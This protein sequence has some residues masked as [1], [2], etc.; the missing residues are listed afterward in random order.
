MK[1]FSKAKLI[2]GALF[3]LVFLIWTILVLFIDVKAIG[4]NETR[5]G[6][7]TFNSWFFTLTGVNMTLYYAT[8]ILSL[9]PFFVIFGFALL[10]L[11][12][13][14]K[15][16]SLFRVDFDILMLG[17]HYISVLFSY[18]LFEIIVVNYRPILIESQMEA[19]YPSSTT[20]LI[21]TVMVPLAMQINYRIKNRYIKLLILI[22]ISIFTAFMIIGRILSGVHWSSDIIGGMLLSIGYIFIYSG[23]YK[24]N[25]KK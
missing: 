9:V 2:I 3:V 7:S 22:L 14:I 12:Q 4:P 5:V 13:L 1:R 17:A 15:R 16:K 6:F 23:I 24:I 21:M 19:S 8:D 11:V 10:G 25:F 18:L 20:M